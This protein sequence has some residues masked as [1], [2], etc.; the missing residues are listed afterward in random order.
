MIASTNIDNPKIVFAGVEAGAKIFVELKG[1]ACAA[2]AIAAEPHKTAS[3]EQNLIANASGLNHQERR[4]P[5][6]VG[7]VW[8]RRGQRPVTLSGYS[9]LCPRRHSKTIPSRD[10]F[11]PQI[12]QSGD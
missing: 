1:P 11:P 2:T 7:R 4:R 9:A 8:P 3:R 6:F 5:Y 10:V 12:R